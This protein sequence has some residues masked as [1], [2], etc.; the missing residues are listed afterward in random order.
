VAAARA[1]GLSAEQWC[2]DDGHDVL[3]DLLAK[4]GISAEFLRDSDLFPS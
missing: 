1:A 2:L 4:N 3:Y